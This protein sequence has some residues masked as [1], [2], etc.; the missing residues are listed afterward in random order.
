PR[1]KVPG[2][3]HIMQI[4]HLIL[5]KGSAVDRDSHSLSVF[6]MIEQMQIQA[7][8]FPVNVPVHAV[9]V[10]RRQNEEKGTISDSWQMS[11]KAPDG[12]TLMSQVL[13]VKME[14]KH[15]RQR[16][17]VNFPMQILSDGTYVIELRNRNNEYSSRELSVDVKAITDTPPAQA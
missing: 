12:K 5:A 17:R 13:E 11:L 10:F 8:Q 14:D 3:I 7:P 6:E 16:L 9:L 15:R 1:V 4:E 2:K